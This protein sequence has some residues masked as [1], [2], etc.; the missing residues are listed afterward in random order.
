M[1]TVEKY[2]ASAFHNLSERRIAGGHAFY[3]RGAVENSE[4]ARN[5]AAAFRISAR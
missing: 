1:I 2:W 3:K 5:V 4:N